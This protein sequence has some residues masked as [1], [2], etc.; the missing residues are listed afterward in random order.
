MIIKCVSSKYCANVNWIFAAIFIVLG[1]SPWNCARRRNHSWPC[2][3]GVVQK[4]F[5]AF[6]VSQL[7]LFFLVLLP[8]TVFSVSQ[9]CSQTFFTLCILWGISPTPG[10]CEIPA[11]R[12][13]HNQCCENI[14]SWWHFIHSCFSA[15][16]GRKGTHRGLFNSLTH[17]KI[18]N[19]SP[20]IVWYFCYLHTF[21]LGAEQTQNQEQWWHLCCGEFS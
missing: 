21:C 14:W 7:S 5:H 15:L 8:P 10:G 4:T 19:P 2:T 1:I 16:A 11:L 20:G 6:Y 13:L 17:S 12:F 3:C 18:S 9:P